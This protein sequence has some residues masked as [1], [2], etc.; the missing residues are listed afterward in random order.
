[1]GSLLSYSGLTTKL[2]A[3][4]A[5]LLTDEDYARISEFENASELIKMLK[6]SPGYAELFADID[7]QDFRR[8]DV[9][10]L[11]EASF[12]RDFAKIYRFADQKQREFLKIYFRTFEINFLKRSLRLAFD[13]RTHIPNP[14]VYP[15][16]FWAHSKLDPEKLTDVWTVRGLVDAL[17]G[18]EYYKPLAKLAEDPEAVIFD[19]EMA[20]DMF[21]FM[22]TWKDLKKNI[23]GKDLEE[24]LIAYGS[25]FDMINLNWID[26]ARRFY[27][28]SPEDIIALLIPVRFKLNKQQIKNLVYAESEEKFTEVLNTTWYARKFGRLTPEELGDTYVRVMRTVLNKESKKDPYSAAMT[29]TY[30]Y[31]KKHETERLTTA[32]ECLTYG[33]EPKDTL[34]YVLRQ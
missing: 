33:M 20:L 8:Y 23:S 19:Y 18:T 24:L 26:R 29:Y 11:F 21:S 3:M 25:R 14:R 13:E 17:A 22:K 2:K 32:V 15:D 28:Q 27:S 34:K 7:E 4:R 31:K 9:E 16:F 6:T 12:I 30:L 1:M 10:S 5:K